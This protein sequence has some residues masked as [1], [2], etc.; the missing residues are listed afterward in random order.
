MMQRV[1]HPLWPLL[2]LRL[3]TGDIVLRIPGE[4]ELAAFNDVIT[5]GIHPPDE[6]PFGIP[7]TIVP[8]PQRERDSYQWWMSTRANW[9]V[10]SWDLGLGVWVAGEP[11]GFQDLIGRDFPALRTVRSGSWLGSRFQ[12]RGVGKLMRQAVLALAFDHLGAE[13]AESE[14]F[15]DNPAS[16]RVSLAVGYNANGYGQL[17]PQ[18]VARTTQRFRMTLEDWRGQARP[19]V[20][21]EG[22][23]PCL[24]LFGLPSA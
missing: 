16:N 21:V 11:A 20:T 17:A 13:V 2:D 9:S 15:L 10:G 22:L 18:G 1:T 7:W 6:M 19:E 24:G 8:S 4:A 12:G 5:A 23:E 14:A 3:S